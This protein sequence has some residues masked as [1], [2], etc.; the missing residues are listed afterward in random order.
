M[1]LV[2]GLGNPGP[3]Y[4]RHRH[5]I[6]ARCVTAASARLGLAFH[7]AD[8]AYRAA[9]GEGPGGPLTLLLPLTFMNRS[10]DALSAWAARSGWRVGAEP[11]APGPAGEP[12]GA[13][14]ESP[15]VVPSVVCDDLH[16]PLGALRIRARGG[17]GGQNGLASLIAAAGGEGVPR[18]RLGVGPREGAVPPEAW[19]EYVLTDFA[20]AEEPA[21]AEL[22]EY[23]VDA[24]LELLAAGPVVAA[25]RFNRPAPAAGDLPAG[26]P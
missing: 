15:E 22:V 2:L 21:V 14:P 26:G 10:G 23:G 8:P 12:A 13:L 20:A 25:S 17:D 1:Q 3:R 7:D 9:V 24:L 19:A 11:A 18:L 6:G 4:A 16:L 5:N